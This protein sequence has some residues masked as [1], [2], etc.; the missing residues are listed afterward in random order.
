LHGHAVTQAFDIRVHRSE[1]F[2]IHC[3]NIHSSATASITA[4][5]A[6]SH[7]AIMI[8]ACLCQT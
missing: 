5:M 2:W 6:E 4:L 3:E 8:E 7:T 1:F